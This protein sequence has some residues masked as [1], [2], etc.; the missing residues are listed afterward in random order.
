M[1]NKRKKGYKLFT[2][3][4][5]FIL[6][7]IIAEVSSL[8]YA[9]FSKIDIN[10]NRKETCHFSSV[11]TFS[12]FSDFNFTVGFPYRTYCAWQNQII[13]IYFETKQIAST[14]LDKRRLCLS[15]FYVLFFF[16]FFSL[17]HLAHKWFENLGPTS[18]KWLI[19][20]VRAFVV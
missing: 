5:A 3:S 11:G 7:H 6:L 1:T 17:L 8:R 4:R 13:T 16:L 9:Q 10:W 19:F 2:Y 18:W 12:A 20:F 15:F 14:S